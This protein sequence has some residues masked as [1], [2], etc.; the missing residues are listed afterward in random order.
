MLSSATDHV[1]HSFFTPFSIGTSIFPLKPNPFMNGL[2]GS[3]PFPAGE[4][5]GRSNSTA[6]STSSSNVVGQHKGLPMPIGGGASESLD[7]NSS[8]TTNVD[9]NVE[10]NNANNTVSGSTSNA[11]V[12]SASQERLFDP[13]AK[14]L[15]FE[16]SLKF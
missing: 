1:Q 9:S 5:N 14:V 16:L 15:P 2:C 10:H 11:S 8:S 7:S 6:S 4:H 12:S 13:F 3:D